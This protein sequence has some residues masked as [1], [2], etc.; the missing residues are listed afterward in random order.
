MLR[1]HEF[2]IYVPCSTREH[3]TWILYV[4]LK[5]EGKYLS[6]RLVVYGDLPTLRV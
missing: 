3:M 1:G 2:V 6:I 5:L 4:E